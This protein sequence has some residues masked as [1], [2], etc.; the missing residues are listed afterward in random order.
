MKTEKRCVCQ[1]FQP[2]I[3]MRMSTVEGLRPHCGPAASK[4]PTAAPPAPIRGTVVAQFK[5]NTGA[6]HPLPPPGNYSCRVP[7]ARAQI[8]L[9]NRLI[10]ET[11][12][13][14]QRYVYKVQILLLNFDLFLL[15]KTIFTVPI[16]LLPQHNDT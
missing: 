10:H 16:I 15:M 1:S 14:I 8:M 3:R 4:P 11:L 6:P 7:C 5:N 9:L 13:E 12:Q 2:F